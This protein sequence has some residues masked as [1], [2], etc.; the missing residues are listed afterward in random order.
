MRAI[1]LVA[2]LLGVVAFAAAPVEAAETKAA[3]RSKAAQF[4]FVDV[5]AQSGV[6]SVMHAGR[7]GK[8]HLLDST[9]SGVAFL[10]YDGDARLDIYLVNGWLLDG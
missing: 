1:A 8:D 7:P 2:A 3:P 5:A 4:H 6:T 10:D 9:G